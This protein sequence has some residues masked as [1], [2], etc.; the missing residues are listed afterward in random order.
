MAAMRLAARPNNGVMALELSHGIIGRH[1]LVL[2]NV[3]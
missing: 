2:R 3:F 1:D